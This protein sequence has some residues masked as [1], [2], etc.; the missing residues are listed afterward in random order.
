MSDSVS[1]TPD[2]LFREEGRCGFVTLDRSH[3]LNALTHDMVKAMAAQYEKWIK[4]PRIYGVIV[5]AVPG[6]A[7]C[8]GAD[9]RALN[10]D[11]AEQTLPFFKDEY[12]LNGLLETFTKPNVALID[13]IIMG[14]GAGI[15]LYGTHR[16]AGE[17]FLFAMPEVAIGF[18]P[19]ICGG[20]FLSRFR[21]Q[22][23]LYLAL[24]GRTIDRA[25]AYYL[26]IVTHCISAS[27]FDAIRNAMKESDPI[28]DIL[29]ALHRNPD[30]SPLEDLQKT[31]D[32]IFA[33]PTVE[34]I[35]ARLDA[36]T[37]PHTDW[38][39]ETA[40]LIRRNAPL[41]LKVTL[42]HLRDAQK[43]TSLKEV[44]EVDYR[45]VS[46]FLSQPSF[47]EGIRA[48]L[49]DKDR[50]PKWTPGTLAEVTNAMIENLFA[51]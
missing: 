36:Q 12:H 30:E 2:I 23:G 14:G 13:G 16:V 29:E 18:F 22:M 37:G 26:D 46:A 19:D 7:F 51:E 28:D 45:L 39:R 31:V 33:E 49:I 34:A 21:G 40:N 44:L 24:T 35:L 47:R 42:K 17:N 5:E 6:R 3:V 25:D 41:S 48:A 20:F 9:L 8:S 32:N 4:V 38:A 11:D 50:A 27:D 15:S 1:S 43:L 10:L